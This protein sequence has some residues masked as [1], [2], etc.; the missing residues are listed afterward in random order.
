[1]EEPDSFGRES[2]PQHKTVIRPVKRNELSFSTI[3][4]NKPLPGPIHSVSQPIQKSILTAATDQMP[5]HI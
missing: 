3:E 2:Q 5:D 4:I 1:M